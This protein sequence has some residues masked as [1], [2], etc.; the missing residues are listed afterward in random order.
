MRFPGLT[1]FHTPTIGPGRRMSV[2]EAINW[3]ELRFGQLT[4]KYASHSGESGSGFCLSTAG[5]RW[6][7]VIKAFG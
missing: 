1:F 3:T 2:E 4:F 7:D 6:G 5:E